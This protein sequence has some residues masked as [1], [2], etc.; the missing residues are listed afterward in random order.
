MRLTRVAVGPV[1][2]GTLPIG[3]ARRLTPAEV[4]A[5]RHEGEVAE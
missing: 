5:L 3:E 4:K 2:L 1:R